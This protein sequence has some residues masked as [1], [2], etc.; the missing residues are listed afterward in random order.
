MKHLIPRYNRVY[1]E[2][3]DWVNNNENK[4]KEC[5]GREQRTMRNPT[6]LFFY[7]AGGLESTM[8]VVWVGVRDIV[9]FEIQL[10]VSSML[11]WPNH[12]DK[13]GK[14]TT[15]SAVRNEVEIEI[16]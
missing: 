7:S 3:E 14:H 13:G 9:L 6:V 5:S 11:I 10:G 16:N 1:W 15:T 2:P 8:I 12:C 4:N